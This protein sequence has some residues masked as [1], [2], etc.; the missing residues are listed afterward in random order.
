MCAP[1][2]TIRPANLQEA[3]DP[4]KYRTGERSRDRHK[5]LGLAY[6]IPD[7][8]AAPKAPQQARSPDSAPL[9]RRNTRGAGGIAVPAG[10]TMLS[11]PGGVTGYPLGGA[12]LLGG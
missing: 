12:T 7:A 3:I 10:G 2:D 6:D 5:A 8:P 4:H 9:Q 1:M 11:G